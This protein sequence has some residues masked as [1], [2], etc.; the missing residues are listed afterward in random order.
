M[1]ACLFVCSPKLNLW[2]SYKPTKIL[3]RVQETDCE[4]AWRCQKHYTAVLVLTARL[5]SY[6]F[7]NFV[8]SY[9]LIKTV[10][11]VILH[12]VR[13]KTHRMTGRMKVDWISGVTRVC[14]VLLFECRCYKNISLRAAAS[15][16]ACGP[17]QGGPAKAHWQRTCQRGR[18][19]RKNTQPQ[20]LAEVF[21]RC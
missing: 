6:I 21:T 5:F 9:K 1:W 10:K 12:K 2:N 3:H 17:N 20:Q 11:C 19:Q 18:S 13:L 7:S 15:P 4:L 14:N 16:L 8:F